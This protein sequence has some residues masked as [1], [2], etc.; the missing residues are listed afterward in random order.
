M[1]TE[2]NNS[3]QAGVPDC[4]PREEY[5]SV[6]DIAR[7]ILKHWLKIAMFVML[8]TIVSAVIFLLMPR[9]YKAEGFL[10]VITP[11]MKGGKVDQASFETIIISHL[12]AI[13]SVFIADE[14]AGAIS[15]EAIEITSSELNQKVK[16][17][18]PPKSNLIVLTADFSSP[19]QAVA[20]LRTWIKKYFASIYKNNINTGLYQIRLMLK[21]TQGE[22]I[23]LQARVDQLETR[24]EQTRPLVDFVRGI[25][26]SRLWRELAT[27]APAE[28]LKDLS[29]IH[30][31]GQEQSEEFLNLKTMLYNADQ[32]LASTVA[33]RGFY[34]D[35]EGCLEYKLRQMNDLH[36]G[37]APQF[38]SNAVLYVK[39]MLKIT[40]VIEIGEPV[41][42]SSYRGALRKTAVAF[43][44]SLVAA[45][46][47]A[48]FC[49]WYKTVK[50]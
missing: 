31:N 28:K 25:D 37:Q 20:V 4:E 41:V 38:S 30:V 19:D 33:N 7:M 49:E 36:A 34:K 12:Q 26:N 50:I 1:A 18:R 9:Q 21:K 17:I 8:V 43:F 44:V 42:K 47:C 23:D 16:I 40:D 6:A 5:I 11:T 32:V 14:V 27:N 48:F 13:Q 22:L 24:I 3:N 35:V 46:F 2:T 29:N 45:S 39:T 10:Q 15:T